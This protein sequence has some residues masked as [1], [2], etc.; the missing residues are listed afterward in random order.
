MPVR[1]APPALTD[2]RSLVDPAL[3]AAIGTLCP[4]SRLLCG[5][6]FGWSDAQ[7]RETGAPR[8]GKALRPALVFLSAR[9]ARARPEDALAGA[10]AVEL[11]HN[12][13]ILHDDVIDRDGRRRHQPTAWTVFGEGPAILAG[14][15]LLTLAWQVLTEC[16]SPHRTEALSRLTQA[17][18]DLIRGQQADLSFE[19]RL[20]VSVAECMDMAAAKTAALMSCSSAIGAHLAGAPTGLV[21]GLASYGRHLGLA[22]QAVDDLLGTWGEPAVTGKPIGNDLRQR[23]KTLPVVFTLCGDDPWRAQLRQIL[24]QER[25]GDRDV[26]KATDLL[27]RSGARQWTAELVEHEIHLALRSLDSQPV[28]VAVRAELEDLARFVVSREA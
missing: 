12:W 6:H 17:V 13:S 16:P 19:H 25:L 21:E 8:A 10:M 26:A 22:F 18:R 9:A 2:A 27:E 3:L 7:G 5:Y 24:S 11:V 20:D 4:K 15:A 28:A 1:T 14:D 23:K